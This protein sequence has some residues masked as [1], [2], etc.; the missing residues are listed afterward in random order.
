MFVFVF[1]YVF[2]FVFVLCICVFVVYRRSGP[3]A[4]VKSSRAGTSHPATLK[5]LFDH[6]TSDLPTLATPICIAASSSQFAFCKTFTFFCDCFQE[7]G[8]DESKSGGGGEDGA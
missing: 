7:S 8:E 1:V 5:A 4:R 2:I 6:F 3:G